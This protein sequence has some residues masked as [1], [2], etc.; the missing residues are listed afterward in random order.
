[1]PLWT[2]EIQA[3]GGDLLTGLR[4]GPEHRLGWPV[5]TPAAQLPLG[6]PFV[7]QG[8]LGTTF[9]GI[10]NGLTTVGDISAVVPSVEGRAWITG[11]NSHLLD[12]DDPFPQG[13]TLGDVWASSTV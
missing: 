10:L 5:C 3:A 2:P 1:M 4:V 11:L 6:Q 8:V 7:H 9:T 12:P 13:Y